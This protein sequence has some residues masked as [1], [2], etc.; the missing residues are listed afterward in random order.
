MGACFEGYTVKADVPPKALVKEHDEM[1]ERCKHEY[2]HGGYSG[3]FA[4]CSGLEVREECFTDVKE[5]FD[6]IAEHHEKWSPSLAVKV[7]NDDPES[8]VAL[9]AIGGWMSS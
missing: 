9:W 3:T 6:W 5:A 7:I 1:I 2:G 4:E 8:P